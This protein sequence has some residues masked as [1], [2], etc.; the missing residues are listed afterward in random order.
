MEKAIWDSKY[1]LADRN[2][3]YQKN[4]PSATIQWLKPNQRSYFFMTG[5]EN[6]SKRSSLDTWR[7]LHCSLLDHRPEKF[8]ETQIN[9]TQSEKTQH[10]WPSTFSA[11]R[12]QSGLIRR[13]R[14]VDHRRSRSCTGTQL[15]FLR[16]FGGRHDK[17]GRRFQW[18][19]QK[20]SDSE[21]RT[22]AYA[23]P[24]SVFPAEAEN[25]EEMHRSKDGGCAFKSSSL[26]PGDSASVKSV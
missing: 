9:A 10:I 22:Q 15:S 8:P 25:V 11:G 1:D 26:C 14:G 19:R 4:H 23:S 7:R 16:S 18:R 17:R 20:D 12:K 13:S 3:R 24:R 6:E 2:T 21:K 5:G